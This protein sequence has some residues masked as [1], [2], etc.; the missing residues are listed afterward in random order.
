MITAGEMPA[1]G[2]KRTTGFCDAKP[3][4]KP[5]WTDASAV[6]ACGL[7]MEFSDRGWGNGGHARADGLGLSALTGIGGAASRRTA[8]RGG[9][10]CGS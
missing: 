4:P 10:C 2:T 5:G 6:G 7:C 3:T 8:V 9:M 1:S